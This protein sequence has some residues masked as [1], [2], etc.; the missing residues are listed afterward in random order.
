VPAQYRSYNFAGKTI[1]LPHLAAY[2]NQYLTQMAGKK[3]DYS[4]FAN[5]F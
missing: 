2:L 5:F 1:V 4:H 3:W